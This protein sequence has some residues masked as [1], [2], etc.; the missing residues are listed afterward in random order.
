MREFEN[1]LRLLFGSSSEP[2]NRRFAGIGIS[3]LLNWEYASNRL[4]QAVQV[5][6]SGTPS[7]ARDIAA[8]R[9][10]G[11]SYQGAEDW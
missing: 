6:V 1:I 2:I 7:I 11:A 4:H 10:S 8:P 9:P 5:V 3:V